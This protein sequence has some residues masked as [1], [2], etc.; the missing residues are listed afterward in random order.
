MNGRETEA[1]ARLVEIVRRLRRE[2]PW[3][4]AQTPESIRHLTIEEVHELS[5]AII[6]ASPQNMKEELGDLLLHVVFYAIMAEERSW[7]S[8]TQVIESLIDKLIKRHPHVFGEAEAGTPDEVKKNWEKLKNKKAASVLEGVPRSLPSLIRAYRIQ[9][10]ASHY[11]FDWGSAG[12]AFPKLSEELEE[13][14]QA[15]EAGD[16]TR[17]EEE[18]GDFLFA[19]VNWARLAGLNPDDALQKSINK[20]VRR[21]QKIEE[22][23]RERGIDLKEMTLQE[24]DRIWE[25]S[26]QQEKSS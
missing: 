11:G 23:A 6:E 18:L 8:L 5:D 24:M 20:F 1:F 26:K 10:R 16:R 12:E 25:E 2:C 22:Y 3:D 15:L 19:V 17:A 13:L 21:F 7:L 9:E 14:R 4:R